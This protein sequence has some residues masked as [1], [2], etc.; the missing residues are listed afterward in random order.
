MLGHPPLLSA[1]LDGLSTLRSSGSSVSIG[2]PS[3]FSS[4]L[5]NSLATVAF[6]AIDQSYVLHA[7]TH[8]YIL[9]FLDFQWNYSKK[10]I[11]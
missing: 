8:I 10:Q 2:L 4:A 9:N 7:R 3:L 6:A 11:K 1:L 5:S